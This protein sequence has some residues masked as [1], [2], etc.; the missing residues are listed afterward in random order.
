MERNGRSVHLAPS[1][2]VIKHVELAV[3]A[4]QSLR[5]SLS[6]EEAD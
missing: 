3:K 4:M 5:V 2:V 1:S 6:E